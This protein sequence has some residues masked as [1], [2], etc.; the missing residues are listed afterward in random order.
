[1]VTEKAWG[2]CYRSR[3]RGAKRIGL[4]SRAVKSF[5]AMRVTSRTFGSQVYVITNEF[6]F[7]L[8]SPRG[9]V[10][11]VEFLSLSRKSTRLVESPVILSFVRSFIRGFLSSRTPRNVCR[12]FTVESTPTVNP[13]PVH[14]PFRPPSMPLLPPIRFEARYFA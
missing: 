9:L 1:M 2:G 11:P 10:P 7:P 14:Y 13:P 8:I 12:R 6:W 3:V 5:G 4:L